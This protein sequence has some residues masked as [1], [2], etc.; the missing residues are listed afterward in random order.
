MPLTKQALPLSASP[1]AVAD[2]RRWVR[3]I[4]LE[5]DREDL[6]E[7]AELGVS[8]LTTNAVLHG[9]EPI[10]VRVRGTAS[11]PRIEVSDGSSQPPTPPS[12][13]SDPEEFLTTFGRGLSIVAMSSVA[14]GAS[15][16]P[17]GKVVW[18]EPAA[19][20]REDGG[21]EAV[22]DSTVEDEPPPVSEDAREIRLLGV[23]LR[24]YSSLSRQYYELRRELRLLAV[25]HQ[26]H[27]PLAADLSAMFAS[28]ERQIPGDLHRA[29]RAARRNG[30]RAVDVSMRM[31]PEASAIVSTMIEMF[32]LAD[33]FCKAERLLSL[34]RTPDQRSFHLWY[35]GEMVRQLAGEQPRSWHSEGGGSGIVDA[36]HVS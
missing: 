34:Q 20:V 19:E 17:D 9:V 33:A 36:Q 31:E 24:L 16:E 28:F 15:I 29:V 12:L 1:R 4:C 3:D 30:A 21:A 11:H 14:W 18:F 7:C 23:D 13:T 26:D 32:D 25:A 10:A 35:L 2:A 6:V 27:Y 5:L 22:I 8:E